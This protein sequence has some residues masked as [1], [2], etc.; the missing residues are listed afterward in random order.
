MP[1]PTD[2]GGISRELF[3]L[4]SWNI[5]CLSRTSGPTNL[6]EMTSPASSGRLQNAIIY[7]RKV[8]KT[9]PKWRKRSI[10]RKW[11]EIRHTIS[12]FQRQRR[13]QISRVKNVGKV[14]ELSGVFRLDPP[15]G[16]LLVGIELLNHTNADA[17]NRQRKFNKAGANTSL[18]NK[19]FILA[20]IYDVIMTDLSEVIE[21]FFAH[22]R[23][24]MQCYNFQA[25]QKCRKILIYS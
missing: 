20:H 14:F 15:Y 4:G 10:I 24:R 7:Y 8:R 13:L 19:A 18:L 9:G 12:V 25:Y 21:H 23:S 11:C 6:T 5:T 17:G 22:T 3:K 1:S 16:G 2:S